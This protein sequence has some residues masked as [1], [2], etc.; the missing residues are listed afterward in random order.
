VRIGVNTMIWSAAFNAAVPL[1]EIK[2]AGADGVEILVIDAAALDVPGL[3]HSLDEYGLDCTF[4]A[5]NPPG[6]NPLAEDA[7]V[8]RETLEHWK[9]LVG[10]A[11]EAGVDLIAGP[12]YAPVGYLPGRRRTGEEWRWAVEFHRQLGPVLE[13]AGVKLAVEPLN[14]FE[15]FFLNTAADAKR[16]VDEVSSP[17]IGILLDTFHANIEEKS[18]A[19]AYRLC[20]R[21]L[22]HVHACENDRGIPGSGHVDWPGVIGALKE[23][24]YDG[25]LTIESFNSK[26][27][28]LSAATAIWRDLAPSSGDIAFEGAAFLRK[29][30][31]A[32]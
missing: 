2:K 16:F 32:A 10:A 15:T 31:A 24:G 6:K 30:W 19:K 7:A 11:A 8:R 29:M 9:R 22:F 1:A 12:T 4:C 5:V 26:I 21:R 20:G 23:I 13:D 17:Q 14:R 25:W 3:R 28:E 27:P 18:V